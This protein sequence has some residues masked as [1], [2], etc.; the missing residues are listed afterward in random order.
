[1]IQITIK[2]WNAALNHD[3]VIWRNWRSALKAIYTSV[4]RC[5]FIVPSLKSAFHWQVVNWWLPGSRD[6]VNT[7]SRVEWNA[8]YGFE[9]KQIWRH[10]ENVRKMLSVKGCITTV[11][12]GWSTSVHSSNIRWSNTLPYRS[13]LWWCGNVRAVACDGA[14]A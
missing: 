4:S 2:Q 10:R 8:A 3:D 14:P 11:A 13:C 5:L 1:M 6:L 9:C 7:T 12:V